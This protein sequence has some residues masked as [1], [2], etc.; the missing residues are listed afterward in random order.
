M[1]G[2]QFVEQLLRRNSGFTAIIVLVLALGLGANALI[3]SM[4]NVVLLMRFP[5]SDAE[6]LVLVQTIDLK[7]TPGGV[8]PAN[9]V[10]WRREAQS[11]EHLSGASHCVRV[12]P[13]G[14]KPKGKSSAPSATSAAVSSTAGPFSMMPI[15]ISSVSS[16]S[17]AWPIC[18]CTPPRTSGHVS[19]S[20]ARS[21]CC[22]SPRAAATR[23]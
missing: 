10:D 11:F 17:I 8:A 19:A 14:R 20:A 3:F 1:R 12:A 16:G 5:Y 23:R 18:V 6:R 15:S 2:T 13:I 21:V 7:G 4:I 9:F 22:C